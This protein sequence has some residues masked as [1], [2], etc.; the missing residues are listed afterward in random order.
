[1]EGDTTS[2]ADEFVSLLINGLI[3]LCSSVPGAGSSLGAVASSIFRNRFTASQP[4]ARRAA[5]LLGWS[6]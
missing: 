2:V 4:V 3:L 5:M 1:M 6:G